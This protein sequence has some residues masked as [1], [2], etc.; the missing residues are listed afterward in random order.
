[1][2][3]FVNDQILEQIAEE[4]AEM[5]GMAVVNE[6]MDR[7]EGSPSPASDSWDEFFAFADMDKLRNDLVM[8]RFEEMSE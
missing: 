8:K 2:S 1:M 5:S 6:V 4:V 3:N 7:P